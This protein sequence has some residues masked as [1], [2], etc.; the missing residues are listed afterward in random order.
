MKALSQCTYFTSQQIIISLHKNTLVVSGHTSPVVLDLIKP[1]IVEVVLHFFSSLIRT[2]DV[3]LR[4][5]LQ[6]SLWQVGSGLSPSLL[7][8]IFFSHNTNW[9]VLPPTSS[10][11]I[12]FGFYP[13][14]SLAFAFCFYSEFAHKHSSLIV[15]LCQ[16]RNNITRG[17]ALILSF[18]HHVQ[19][20][21]AH[22]SLLACLKLRVQFSFHLPLIF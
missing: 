3:T 6:V 1:C 11:A 20:K 22:D 8:T 16:P 21:T 17:K 15:Y 12:A 9:N 13:L 2:Y 5:K 7:P 10:F 14:S 18:S 4:V 19:R